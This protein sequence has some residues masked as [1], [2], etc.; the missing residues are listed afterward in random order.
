[1]DNGGNKLA[2]LVKNT[3]PN[4]S[5]MLSLIGRHIDRLKGRK[6]EKEQCLQIL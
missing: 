2:T 5:T 1:M 3:L 4:L 6:E